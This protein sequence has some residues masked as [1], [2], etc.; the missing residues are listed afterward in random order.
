MLLV[1]DLGFPGMVV[2]SFFSNQEGLNMCCDSN[3]HSA[4]VFDD[5][6]PSLPFLVLI[7]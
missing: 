2:A 4:M 6:S 3:I 1:S 7:E 5:C